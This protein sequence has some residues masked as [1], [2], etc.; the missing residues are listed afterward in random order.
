MA[1]KGEAT[2]EMA[3]AEAL[4]LSQDLGLTKLLVSSDCLAVIKMMQ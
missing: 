1:T 2:Q 4:V 3:C